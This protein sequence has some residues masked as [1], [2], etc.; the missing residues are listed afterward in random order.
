MAMT[1]VSTT[2]VGSGGAASIEFTNIPQTGKDLLVVLSGR[3]SNASTYAAGTIRFNNDTTDANYSIINLNGIDATVTST[4]SNF[5]P[6]FRVVG[7]TATADTFSNG[8]A[9]I[10]NYTS[11]V[12]KSVSVDT[13]N[14]NNSST[15]RNSI[16]AGS[17]SGA[18]AITSVKIEGYDAN[19]MQYSTASLYIIS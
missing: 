19:F 9:Y 12:A 17:W 8:A 13:V 16:F 2:T 4:S 11:S 7:N 15:N 3:Q 5:S 10:S 18:T 14:E 6:F 1:L